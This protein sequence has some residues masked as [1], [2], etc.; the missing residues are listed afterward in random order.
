[1]R[2]R[3]LFG[4]LTLCVSTLFV[5]TASS[6]D[7]L[8]NAPSARSADGSQHDSDIEG[9]VVSKSRNTLVIRSDDNKYHLFTYD[10]RRVR[11]ADVRPGARVRVNGSA[12][13]EEGTQVAEDVSVITPASD[14]SGTRQN[15]RAAQ[16][17]AQVSQVTNQ[18]ESEARRWHAGGR[19][20]VG[21]SPELFMFGVQSQIGPVFSPRVLFRPNADFSFGELTDMVSINLEAAYRFN[22]TFR[23]GW[24]PY[25]GMGP[26]M[27]FIHQ[28]VD[29]A[30]ISFGNFDYK[31]GFNVLVGAQRRG[32][33]V[34]MKTSLW[35]AEAPVLRLIL[36]YNF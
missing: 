17:P 3:N 10:S 13:D 14:G 31:T 11:S 15:A 23:R 9:T 12:P 25:F 1:M 5:V 34:E 24:T 21:F 7:N 19:I 28:G 8:P 32:T 20:G 26:S 33:F 30:D 6:Q 2:A 29:R 4:V 35:S 36:G 16:P 27:N 22:T 18:I